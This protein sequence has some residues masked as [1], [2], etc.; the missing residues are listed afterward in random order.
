MGRSVSIHR[1]AITTFFTHVDFEEEWEWN[2]F[3]S[4]IRY[5][6]KNKFKSLY[7]TDRW[8]GR[9]D[10]VILENEIAEISISEYCGLVAICLAPR[11]DP[12][13]LG[14]QPLCENWC[15][16]ISNNFHKILGE[17]FDGLCMIGRFSNGEAIFER[18]KN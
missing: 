2:N 1:H 8:V 12:R 9:E 11:D 17:A 18:V 7:K 5:I 15:Y 16:Q 13:E 10:H 4:E 3:V 6:L 14:F